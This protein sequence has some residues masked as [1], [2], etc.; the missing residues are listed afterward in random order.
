M[1]SGFV[2]FVALV[3]FAWNGI[4]LRF[5]W[6]SGVLVV[7]D[8]AD[9]IG[10]ETVDSQGKE[11][12]PEDE[13][14]LGLLN[15]SKLWLSKHNISILV[16]KL[17]VENI[18]NGEE[19]EWNDHKDAGTSEWRSSFMGVVVEECGKHGSSNNGWHKEEKGYKYIPPVNVLVQQGVEY[20]DEQE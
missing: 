10:I 13:L 6:S 15:V 1:V 3:A 17:E 19:W 5:L 2:F 18:P 7:G 20:F 16:P 11:D 12:G 4:I 8:N 9:E 14:L